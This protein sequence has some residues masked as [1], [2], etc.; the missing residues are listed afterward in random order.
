MQKQNTASSS[1]WNLELRI[2]NLRVWLL[3][4]I[5]FCGTSVFAQTGTAY[6]FKAGLTLGAQKWN[7][8]ERELLP[9]Y[10][11]ALMMES[12]DEELGISLMGNFV[13]QK[14]GSRQVIRAGSGINQLTGETISYPRRSFRQPFNN[15]MLV[16]AA[17]KVS[18]L[19]DFFN[20]YYGLGVHGD[21]NLSYEVR[22]N[23]I[24]LQDEE[25]RPLDEYRNRFTYG[26]SIIAGIE[27][28][29]GDSG[30]IFFEVSFHPDISKQI[31]LPTGIPYIDSWTGQE[32]T[33]S[34]Q[35][36]INFPIEFSIG[37]KFFRW[38]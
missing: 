36:V 6:G 13:W 19:T 22:Y 28:L 26:G 8:Q 14:K 2:W 7:T 9:G 37:Y 10:H 15:L 25:I 12:R 32:R 21:Y 23:Y 27:Y 18:P 20:Y 33:L 35:E 17:K 3:A 34:K 16:I 30:A 4:G 29:S 5:L 1:A 31:N 11:G 24:N 38:N